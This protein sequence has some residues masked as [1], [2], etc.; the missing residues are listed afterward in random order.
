M[1]KQKVLT[2]IA[3]ILGVLVLYCLMNH[4]EGFVNPT[5]TTKS[6]STTPTNPPDPN[7]GPDGKPLDIFK[8]FRCS[9]KY[10]PPE[11]AGFV[12]PKAPGQKI[13]H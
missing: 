13:R 9:A 6:T 1:R 8:I 2:I 3:V 5:P 11:C 12:I 4:L 7:L 10:P